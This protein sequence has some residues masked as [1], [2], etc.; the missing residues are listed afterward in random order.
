MSFVKLSTT[1]KE[2]L[3]THLRGTGRAMSAAQARA[4]YGIKNIRARMTEMRQAG[5]KVTRTLNTEGRSAYSIS[6]RDV[7]GSRAKVFS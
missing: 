5:L 3:E 1:Q 7:N 4:T 6:S 2:F